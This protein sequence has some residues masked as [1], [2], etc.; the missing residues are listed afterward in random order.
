MAYE[1]YHSFK[2]GKIVLYRRNGKPV[3]HAR[4]A[5]EGIDGYVVRTTKTSDLA[6]AVRIAEDRYED[7]RYRVRNGLETSKLSF[8]TLWSRWYRAHSVAGAIGPYRLKYIKGTVERYFLPFFEGKSLSDLSDVEIARYWDWRRN[9]WSSEAGLAK[10]ENAQKSRTTAKRPYK[11]K[12]GNI[13]KVP[14]PKSLKMEQTVLRQLFSWASQTG[15]IKN[16]PFIHAPV[17]LKKVSETRRPAFSLEEWK[18]IYR[19]LRQWAEG[20]DV[21]GSD[22]VNSKLN[23]YHLRQREMLRNYVL[24]LGRTGIRPNEARQLRWRDIELLKDGDQL[25][26][27]L[28]IA[29]TTK[30]GERDVVGL[31]DLIE[32]IERIRTTSEHNRPNDLVF[33]NGKGEPIENFGKSFKEVLLKLGLLEDRYGRPRTIYSLRHMYATIRMIH[34]EVPV[35][36]LARNMGTSI[37]M[38]EKHYSHVTNRQRVATLSGRMIESMSRKGLNW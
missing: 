21:E 18:R 26:V 25:F 34:G 15:L 1:D 7:F 35:A 19:Y 32:V 14:S 10:I 29:P 8:A 24:L 9:Y 37:S 5:V 3:Y 36:D 13:A 31:G 28:N 16:R 6:E 38:I 11:Q 33:C 22:E 20:K 2:D 17:K 23:S 30:T 12:L 27:V 4:L